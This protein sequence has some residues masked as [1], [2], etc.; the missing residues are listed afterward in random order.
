[1]TE[2]LTSTP[3]GLYC[4]QGNFYVDPW[5]PVDYAIIT[6]AHA[7]HARWGS[8]KYLAAATCRE[9]LRIRMGA[10]ADLTFQPLGK[11]LVIGGVKVTFFPAG[12]ILGSAQVRIERDGQSIVVSG[13]YKRQSDPTCQPFEPIQCNTFVTESTFGLPIYRWPDSQLIFEDINAW[14][15]ENQV[16]GKTTILLAYS[17][18]KAQRMLAGLDDSIGSIYTHGAI[19]K[20]NAGYRAAGVSIPST[21]SVGDVDSKIDWSQS[22]VIAPPSAIGSSW[23]R[24][25]GKMSVGMASGWMQIRGTRRRRSMDRGFVLSDHVDWADLMRT[26]RETEAEQVWVTHGYSSIVA[27]H[28]NEIG[29]HSRVVE[30]EFKGELL[31]DDGSDGITDSPPLSGAVEEISSPDEVTSETEPADG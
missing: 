2:L 19:E 12:H 4:E 23:A 20:L 31:E 26:I 15:R 3:A 10:K 29:I 11:P 9:V 16:A 17:L 6:H 30:T 25:F 27:R 24:R 21:T 7:D 28:L 1:M 18:G 13:D 14:W 5:K 22:L 8:K